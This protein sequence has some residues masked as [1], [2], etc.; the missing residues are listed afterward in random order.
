M[1]E[2]IVRTLV[3]RGPVIESDVRRACEAQ[4]VCLFSDG[5]IGETLRA[6]EL[7]GEIVP[8]GEYVDP[9]SRRVLF[10]TGSSA[11]RVPRLSESDAAYRDFARSLG[12]D[13]EGCLTVTAATDV[14]ARPAGVSEAEEAE[15]QA[16]RRLLL[17]GL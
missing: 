7:A 4:G 16:V 13:E 15:Y 8:S 2:G 9:V 1:V 14:E 11:S 6:L 17:G 3:S 12:I 5:E 10:R